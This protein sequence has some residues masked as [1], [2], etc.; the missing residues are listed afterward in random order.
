[1][2]ATIRLAPNGTVN[3][4]DLIRSMKTFAADEKF[5]KLMDG[6][7]NRRRR[8]EERDTTAPAKGSPSKG[9]GKGKNDGGKGREAGRANRRRWSAH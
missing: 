9:K 7:G 5:S 6:D 8:R 2:M 4:H 1:M 3:A